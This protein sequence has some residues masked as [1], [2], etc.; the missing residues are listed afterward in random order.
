MAKTTIRIQ[1]KGEL[2]ESTLVIHW[3]KPEDDPHRYEAYKRSFSR[4]IDSVRAAEAEQANAQME[5][6]DSEAQ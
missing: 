6:T 3:T 1:V 4:L 5:D 2:R